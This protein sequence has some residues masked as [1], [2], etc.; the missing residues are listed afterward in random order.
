MQT[1]Q[2]C[3]PSHQ[4][5][6]CSDAHEFVSAAGALFFHK[7][8]GITGDKR[9]PRK[10]AFFSLQLFCSSS[11]GRGQSCPG[12]PFPLVAVPVCGVGGQG[13]AAILLAASRAEEVPFLNIT[14][15][16]K[17]LSL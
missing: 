4:H 15:G 12:A 8:L 16:K 5:A 3:V 1:G 6:A 2:H 7:Q 17:K 11:H 14:W 13:A 9:V 10:G